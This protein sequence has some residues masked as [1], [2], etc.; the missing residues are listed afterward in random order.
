MANDGVSLADEC[1]WNLFLS[2]L[3]SGDTVTDGRCA[4]SQKSSYFGVRWISRSDF[5][6]W[7]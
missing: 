2:P 1:C 6:M 4:R 7:T 3:R 5:S